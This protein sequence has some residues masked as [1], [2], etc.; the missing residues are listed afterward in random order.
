VNSFLGSL[1]CSLLGHRWQFNRNDM[2][3][4]LYDLPTAVCQRCAAEI[5]NVMHAKG[6]RL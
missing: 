4:V 6:E 2:A 3:V 5:P 1:L